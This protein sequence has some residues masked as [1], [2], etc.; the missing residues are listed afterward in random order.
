MDIVLSLEYRQIFLKKDLTTLERYLQK[1]YLQG[2]NFR[3]KR[4]GMLFKLGGS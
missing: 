4:D 2:G 1:K 3:K